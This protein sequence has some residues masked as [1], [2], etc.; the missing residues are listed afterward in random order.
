[1]DEFHQVNQYVVSVM[2]HQIQAILLAMRAGLSSCTIDDG[3]E[4][5]HFIHDIL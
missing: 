2:L 3:K 5:S 1:M 4:V